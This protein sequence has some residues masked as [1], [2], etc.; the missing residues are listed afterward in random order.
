MRK[1]GSLSAPLVFFFFSNVI[2]SCAQFFFFC[3]SGA[4]FRTSLHSAVVYVTVFALH[5]DERVRSWR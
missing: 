3:M 2:H 4:A 5:I 1:R